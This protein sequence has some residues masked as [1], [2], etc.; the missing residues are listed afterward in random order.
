M[1][2]R[3][4]I[5]SET[6]RTARRSRTACFVYVRHRWLYER[7]GR[8]ATLH[9]PLIERAVRVVERL[10]IQTG[11]RDVDRVYAQLDAV[12]AAERVRRFGKQI[13]HDEASNSAREHVDAVAGAA[14]IFSARPVAAAVEV[15]RILREPARPIQTMRLIDV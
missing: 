6:P 3:W 1:P 15:Q 4:R 2:E 13:A 14:R 7:R 12:E 10:Q 5:A 9:E 8:T 11:L